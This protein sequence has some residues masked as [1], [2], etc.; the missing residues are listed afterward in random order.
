MT[1]RKKIEVMES[2]E[3]GDKIEVADLT[4]GLHIPW[5]Q[6]ATNPLWNWIDYDYRVKPKPKQVIVIEKWL[7]KHKT[8]EDQY[9]IEEGNAKEMET[10]C[11][12]WS[13]VKL[14]ATYEV[15][16]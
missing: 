14:L 8:K 7:L 3:R 16:L 6:N 15:E 9:A 1:L 5:W 10:W 11:N 4:R 2:F 13:K 12:V